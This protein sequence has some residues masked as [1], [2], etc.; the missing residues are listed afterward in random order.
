MLKKKDNLTDFVEELPEAEVVETPEPQEEQ[1][2]VD[3]EGELITLANKSKKKKNLRIYGKSFELKDIERVVKETVR[4]E[5]DKLGD[6]IVAVVEKKLKNKG[7][8]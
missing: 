6:K 1:Q 4:E 3:S 7:L 5:I 2:V 8:L